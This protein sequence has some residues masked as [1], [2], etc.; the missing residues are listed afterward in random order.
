MG[1]A[2]HTNFHAAFS[3]EALKIAVLK[4]DWLAAKLGGSMFDV[5]FKYDKPGSISAS[6]T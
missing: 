1:R 3:C 5:I 2:I 6:C 4:N